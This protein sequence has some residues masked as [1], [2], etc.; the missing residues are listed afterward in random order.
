MTNKWLVYTVV[1]RMSICGR[2]GWYYFGSFHPGINPM[3]SHQKSVEQNSI[4]P[5][6]ERPSISL[7]FDQYS[8]LADPCG[9]NPVQCIII[10]RITDTTE[11]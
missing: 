9:I 4:M 6:M 2:T 1:Y 10:M 7:R 5:T 3:V 8:F 11:L